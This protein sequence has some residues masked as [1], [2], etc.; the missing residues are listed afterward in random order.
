M[1]DVGEVHKL[2]TFCE[3]IVG[4]FHGIFLHTFVDKLLGSDRFPNSFLNNS[5]TSS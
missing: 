1:L 4:I 3:V 2:S 5:P